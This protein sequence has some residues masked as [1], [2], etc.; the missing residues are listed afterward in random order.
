[1]RSLER[2][3]WWRDWVFP[4]PR[5]VRSLPWPFFFPERNLGSSMGFWLTGSENPDP[6]IPPNACPM[7]IP[8][9]TAKEYPN[10]WFYPWPDYHHKLICN[11]SQ[12]LTL[13]DSQRMPKIL[14]AD[15]AKIRPGE[16]F[17]RP[18]DWRDVQTSWRWLW[19][20]AGILC[21]NHC[22]VNSGLIWINGN[23][24][25]TEKGIEHLKTSYFGVIH[26][27]ILFRIYSSGV[28]SL[29]CSLCSDLVL[30]R[31][32]KA[33]RQSLFLQTLPPFW[34]NRR[35]GPWGWWKGSV[36]FRSLQ[37]WWVCLEMLRRPLNH[38]SISG[39]YPS[40]SFPSS[41][42][43]RYN[44]EVRSYPL[45]SHYVSILGLANPQFSGP[46]PSASSL[47]KAWLQELILLQAGDVLLVRSPLW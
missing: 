11:M 5:L 29:C 15:S 40:S 30:S 20:W 2:W 37:K 24:L 31:R 22:N 6:L 34:I 23:P 17:E 47:R 8:V 36:L 45:K 33:Q 16:C 27:F 9:E 7:Q 39:I 4:V 13:R 18:R 35:H 42:R 44:W 38:K 3:G 32:A 46:Y 28:D 14:F 12:N 19:L 25:S 43:H 21:C 26:N 41:N 10:D 1:M